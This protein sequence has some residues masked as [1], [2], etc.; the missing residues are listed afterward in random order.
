MSDDWYDRIYTNGASIRVLGID[1]S[2]GSNDPARIR[3]PK[4]PRGLG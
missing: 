2:Q 1:C 3:M 4:A